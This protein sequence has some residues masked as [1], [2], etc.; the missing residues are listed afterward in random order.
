[1]ASEAQKRLEEASNNVRVITTALRS[2]QETIATTAQH[3]QTAQLQL[4][5]HDQLLFTARQKVDALSAQLVGL[6]AEVGIAGDTAS[7]NLPALL[8]KLKEP[9]HPDEQPKP[10]L[11]LLNS[12]GSVG[13]TDNGYQIHNIKPYS[14][15]WND[16]KQY[17]F[18]Q[19][20]NNSPHK[21][22][23]SNIAEQLRHS[24]LAQQKQIIRLSDSDYLSPEEMQKFLDWIHEENR[25]DLLT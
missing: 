7:I 23:R 18:D 13:Y 19:Q 24:R 3:A 17:L 1:M 25:K 15:N 16:Y 20:K 6:Q 9:L 22:K 21:L 11:P 10:P 12:V 2:A 8:D 5:A 4:A 14:T